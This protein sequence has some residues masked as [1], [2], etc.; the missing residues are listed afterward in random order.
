MDRFQEIDTWMSPTDVT[1]ARLLG[2]ENV[3]NGKAVRLNV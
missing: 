2:V 1:P 3:K